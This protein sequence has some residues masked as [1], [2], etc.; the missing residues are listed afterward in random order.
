MSL[1]GTSLPLTPWA[2]CQFI[3]ADQKSSA[4]RRTDA[5]DPNRMCLVMP[6]LT[7]MSGDVTFF[8][9]PKDATVWTGF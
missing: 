4:E 5:L 9:L 7:R 1:F 3:G 6:K 2:S 8:R